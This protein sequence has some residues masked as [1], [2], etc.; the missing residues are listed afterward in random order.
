[1]ELTRIWNCPNKLVLWLRPNTLQMSGMVLQVI[2]VANLALRLM[3]ILFRD[4][5]IQLLGL[6]LELGGDR[7]RS[8]CPHVSLVHG[9]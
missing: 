4:K 8:K 6:V 1:M 3:R 9:G 7:K 5:F 2:N